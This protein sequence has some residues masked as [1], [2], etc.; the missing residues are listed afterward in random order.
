MNAEHSATNPLGDPQADA[1][2]AEEREALRQR[3]AHL[4]R[5]CD[6]ENDSGA[7]MLFGAVLAYRMEAL[8]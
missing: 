6:M 1:R 7:K 8:Q 2:R 4:F 3:L 5:Q